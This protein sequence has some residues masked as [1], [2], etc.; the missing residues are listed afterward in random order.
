MLQPGQQDVEVDG[1]PLVAVVD[2]DL[3]TRAT[4]VGK[5]SEGSERKNWC[6]WVLV[7][8]SRASMISALPP[9]PATR[10]KPDA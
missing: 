7:A 2:S 3:F 6:S 10:F 5:R 4:R 9:E 8:G 1:E